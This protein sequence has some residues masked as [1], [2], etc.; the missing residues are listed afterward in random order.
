MQEEADE[1]DDGDGDGGEALGLVDSVGEGEVDG[2]PAVH[3]DEQDAEQRHVQQ[4]A[5]DSLVQ[6]ARHAL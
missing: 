5:A 4:R 1:P 6:V 2:P 3:G